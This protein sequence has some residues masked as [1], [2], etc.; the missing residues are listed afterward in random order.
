[1]QTGRRLL[2][3][4]TFDIRCHF[5]KAGDCLLRVWASVRVTSEVFLAQVK[6]SSGRQYFIAPEFIPGV[7]KTRKTVRG[8]SECAID[9]ALDDEPQEKICF[10]AGNILGLLPG[11][12]KML[13]S[14]N[15]F[16]SH[17]LKVGDRLTNAWALVTATS[18]V[19]WGY[20]GNAA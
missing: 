14:G 19:Y 10:R 15:D 2:A 7:K 4:S 3:K 12:R 20:G 13:E 17:I 8:V 18:E 1:M 9:Y 16:Q 11:K 5:G 6:V